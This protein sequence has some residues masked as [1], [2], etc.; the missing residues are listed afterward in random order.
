MN[1]YFCDVLIIGG[2]LAGI[3]TALNINESKKII[4][5]T[6]ES[7]SNSRLAQGGI[8]GEI[9][10]DEEALAGHIEDTLIAGAGL[11]DIQTVKVLVK[12]AKENLERLIELGVP[13]DL[14]NEGKLAFTKEGGHRNR[15]ILHAGGDQTGLK[16]METLINHLKNRPNIT[17]LKDYMM[18]DL[19]CNDNECFGAK[20]INKENKDVVVVAGATVIATG[21]IGGLYQA[22]TNPRCATGDGIA[23]AIRAQVEV[24]DLE[25]VQFHPTVFW[26]NN[27]SSVR[28][29]ISEAVRGEGA[30]LL[31][32]Y[33]QRFMEKYDER[34]ELAPRDVVSRAIVRELELTESDYVFI[35]ARHLGKAFLEKRFPTIYAKCLESGYQMEKDLIPVS[36][37]EHFGIGGIKIDLNGKTS[38]K[39][40]YANGECASSGVHGANRLA[41]NS[42]LECVVFGNRIAKSINN[43]N[44]INIT[45]ITDDQVKINKKEADYQSI[46]LDV[47]SIMSREVG[48]IRTEKGL[49]NAEIIVQN[50]Y[51]NLVNN[52]R[53]LKDYYEC[54]NVVTVS[55][56]IIKAALTRKE[57]I[58]CHYRE[59]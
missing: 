48:I 28:F 17:L 19:M 27:E 1:N 9:C 59:D 33:Y 54:L 35:D 5:V 6:K 50:Y 32:R 34:L 3:Y 36:P 4:I 47:Q 45:N 37:V 49:K 12:E 10:V 16:I 30:F 15:R 25:F 55:L 42:L 14:N 22:S 57:S 20:F 46:K 7:D 38:T 39:N 29:L 2:G 23:S 40:L 43:F 13:F 8:A 31:N 24:K 51:K 56:A 58:G 52:P 11:N 53:H 41:S 18:Y 21:G 26:V 44:I